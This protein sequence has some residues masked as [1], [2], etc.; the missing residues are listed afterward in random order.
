MKQKNVL[1]TVKAITLFVGLFLFISSPVKAQTI[2]GMNG[3]SQRKIYTNNTGKRE[4]DR[5]LNAVGG[6]ENAKRIYEGIE[7]KQSSK[8]FKAGELSKEEL[9]TLKLATTI[10]SYE[11]EVSQQP[12]IDTGGNQSFSSKSLLSPATRTATTTRCSE[13]YVKLSSRNSLGFIPYKIT[14]S[15][16]FCYDG[17]KITKVENK[18]REIEDF[19]YPLFSV[20]FD[21]I[22]SESERQRT[23]NY[24]WYT[25][26]KFRACM[27]K[28]GCIFTYNPS[29]RLTAYANGR[30]V[31]NVV[32]F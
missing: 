20:E 11:V 21:K 16:D 8:D 26:A 30:V 9:Q 5:L 13:A 7:R 19:N 25:K 18:V 22:T 10:V 1:N 2:S 12:S 15:F 29:I 31:A 6:I 27:V 23:D 28:Y 4:S 32:K 14:K 24:Y 3:I 17:K